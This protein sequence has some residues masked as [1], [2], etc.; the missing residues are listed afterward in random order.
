[1]GVERV[2]NTAMKTRSE[3]L[4]SLLKVSR[5]ITRIGVE[6]SEVKQ[7]RQV[8]MDSALPDAVHAVIVE[9]QIAGD[10]GQVFDLSLGGQHTVE[11]IAVFAR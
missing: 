10:D 5:I 9:H 7:R 6:L 1:M 11:W 4:R 3:F 8:E 2:G